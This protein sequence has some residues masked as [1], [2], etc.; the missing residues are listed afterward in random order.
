MNRCKVSVGILLSLILLCVIALI[1]VQKQCQEYLTLVDEV[2]SAV[3]AGDISQ[4]LSG[5]DTL[6]ERWESYHNINGLFV[7]GMELD[8][9]REIMSGLRPLIADEHPE[10]ESELRKMRYLILSMYEEELPELWH[11]L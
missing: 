4:A 10:V 6:E 7:N 11:I 3:E 9:I 8:A 5:F 2:S 1:E